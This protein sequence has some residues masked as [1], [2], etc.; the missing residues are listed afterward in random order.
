MQKASLY[1]HKFIA[2]I[3]KATTVYRLTSPLQGEGRM[4]DV[5]QKLK[6]WNFIMKYGTS[7]FGY[8]IKFGYFKQN[9]LLDIK[10]I[11]IN[12][13]QKHNTW[14]ITKVEVQVLNK[15]K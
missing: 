10:K 11:I 1:T 13:Q 9:V 15:I 4:Y 6:S 3:I 2:I 7:T 8:S 12:I 5:V 14:I